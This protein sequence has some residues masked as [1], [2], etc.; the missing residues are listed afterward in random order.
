VS[1]AARD[2]LR[3]PVGV[4][5]LGIDVSTPALK[6]SDDEMSVVITAH[7]RP[8]TVALNAGDRL[9]VSYQV[10]DVDGKVTTGA[11]KVFGIDL[12]PE[13]RARA[14]NEGLHF[15]ER[16]TLEPGRYELRLV[17]EQPGGPMGSV[18]AHIDAETFDDD[19][20]LSGVS[21]AP[22]QPGEVVLVGDAPIRNVLT[23]DPTARRAF[24]AAEGLDVYAEVYTRLDER[25]RKQFRNTDSATLT[26]TITTAAGDVSVSKPGQ[27]VVAEAVGDA[28]REGF[29]VD[30]GIAGLKPGQYVLT[31]EGRSARD[32]KREP[33]TRQIPFEI[34]R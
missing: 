19:L 24:R 16:I 15:A 4:P 20:A 29:R 27:R 28:L 8:Q 25:T 1:V 12:G 31:V 3:R 14:A 11:Y 17:A 5:G 32:R 30:A 7:V 22:R 26:A 23:S 6:G 18:V 2:A 21:L 33:V 9:A 13:N 34:V 10:L